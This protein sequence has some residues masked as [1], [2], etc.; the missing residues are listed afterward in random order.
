MITKIKKNIDNNRN[1]IG[2]DLEKLIFDGINFSEIGSLDI[3]PDNLTR[4][5]A[6]SRSRGYQNQPQTQ[7]YKTQLIQL[8]R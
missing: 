8:F 5:G 1:K 6:S 2:A 3:K 7:K 4:D